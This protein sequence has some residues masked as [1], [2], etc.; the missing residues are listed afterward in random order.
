MSWR[1]E[2]LRGAWR[3]RIRKLSDDELED[4]IED[5]EI[6]LRRL[7]HGHR[8]L[9]V[10]RDNTDALSVLSTGVYPGGVERRVTVAERRWWIALI[11]ARSRYDEL[12]RVRYQRLKARGEVTEDYHAW[13]RT[14]PSSHDFVRPE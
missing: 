10:A 13:H 6:R 1:Q 7:S 2:R 14:Q 4:V 8:G 9:Q 3:R 12:Q 5:M 11:D